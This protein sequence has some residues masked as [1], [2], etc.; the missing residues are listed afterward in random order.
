MEI[1]PVEIDFFHAKGQTSRRD[2]ANSRFSNFAKVPK[3]RR[4]L[5]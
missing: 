3:K 5:A 1:R 4:H 2:E